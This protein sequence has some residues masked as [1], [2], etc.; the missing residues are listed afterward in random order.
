MDYFSIIV[1]AIGLAMDSLAVCISQSMCRVSFNCLRS[2]KIAFVF[3]LFQGGMLLIGFL[4]GKGFSRWIEAYDHWFAFVILLFIGLHMI[5]ESLGKKDNK[6]CECV[7][8]DQQDDSVN[9]RKVVILSLATSI[10]ALVTGLI[11][12]PFPDSIIGA[13]LI[14]G[15]VTLFFSLAGMYAGTIFGRKVNFDTALIGGLM[16]IGIGTKILIEHTL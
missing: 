3:A 13:I 10:D 5:V 1:I 15:G 9:W 12:V 2:F 7:C 6:E 8:N 16:L 14:I 4:L 11:F